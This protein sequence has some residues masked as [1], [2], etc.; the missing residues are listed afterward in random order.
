MTR[1]IG[2]PPL[3]S[4]GSLSNPV[5]IAQGGTGATTAAGALAAGFAL[6]APLA[7]AKVAGK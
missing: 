3:P 7:A 4:S 5:A 2:F 1:A 6:M